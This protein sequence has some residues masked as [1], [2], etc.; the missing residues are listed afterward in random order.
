MN[1]GNQITNYYIT[2][3]PRVIPFMK[4]D[5]MKCSFINEQNC[6]HQSCSSCSGTGRRKDGT[7]CVHMIS[8]PCK[9]CSPCMM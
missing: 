1:N 9:N 3:T 2:E 6:L 5:F 7:V 8:C 4:E